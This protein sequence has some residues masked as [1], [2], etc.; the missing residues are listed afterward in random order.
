MPGV[1]AYPIHFVGIHCLASSL[2]GLFFGVFSLKDMITLEHLKGLL[3]ILSFVTG[4]LLAKKL[5]S[6]EAIDWRRFA[7]EWILA[8]MG[9]VALWSAGVLEG[10]SL[11][12]MI[13]L[14]SAAGL[15]GV[16]AL[17]WAVK[18]AMHIKKIQ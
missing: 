7:G 13:L 14:G 10:L 18:L 2:K 6:D 8:L 15:G 17:E 16:R 11:V 3:A 12:H 4:G 9:G 1:S 5:I